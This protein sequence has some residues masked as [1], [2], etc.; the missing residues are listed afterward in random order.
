MPKHS[1]TMVKAP[2]LMPSSI[3][4]I[5]SIETIWILRVFDISLFFSCQGDASLSEVSPSPMVSSNRCS[6]PYLFCKP[7]LWI[8]SCQ[9]MTIKHLMYMQLCPFMYTKR[10]CVGFFR[11]RNSSRKIFYEIQ[12]VV[13]IKDQRAYMLIMCQKFRSCMI[14]HYNRLC[15]II[16]C[17]TCKTWGLIYSHAMRTVP[18]SCH[19]LLHVQ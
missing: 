3:C 5:W 9:E 19:M 18:M 1:A 12:S 2:L 14:G 8:V 4:S 15:H 11:F 6:K 7:L 10:D 16:T 17:N 13:S